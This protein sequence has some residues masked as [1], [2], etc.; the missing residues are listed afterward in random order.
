MTAKKPQTSPTKSPANT[1]K[2]A[3]F[4]EHLRELDNRS[5][6]VAIVFLLARCA[7]YILREENQ[8]SG[9]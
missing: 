9:L 5:I 6:I 7:S 2:S 8:T 4:E 3:T 1:P